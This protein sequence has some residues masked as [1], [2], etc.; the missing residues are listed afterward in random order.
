MKNP[1]N[2]KKPYKASP[3]EIAECISTGLGI[4]IDPNAYRELIEQIEETLKNYWR[5]R[6]VRGIRFLDVFKD[7]EALDNAI[8]ALEEV[9]LKYIILPDYDLAGLVELHETSFLWED[10]YLIPGESRGQKTRRRK[11]KSIIND[12]V[13]IKKM[14]LGV[15]ENKIPQAMIALKDPKGW[16]AWRLWIA[17]R[18]AFHGH[19]LHNTQIDGT[20]YRLLKLY[21]TEEE[22][23][24]NPERMMRGRRRRFH[25]KIE[26]YLSPPE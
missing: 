15:V 7:I 25:K 16:L 24:S 18:S 10:R 11:I 19:T 5:F 8:K 2:K 4:N 20:A 21:G 13:K 14:F 12:L 22:E 3:K 9:R 17:L 1:P 6:T 23:S 26:P